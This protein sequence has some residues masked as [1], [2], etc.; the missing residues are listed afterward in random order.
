ML[1]CETETHSAGRLPYSCIFLSLVPTLKASETRY[2]TRVWPAGRNVLVLS[3]SSDSCDGPDACT[4]TR[5]PGAWRFLRHIGATGFRVK[6]A[7]CQEAVWLGRSCF[8]GRMVV[9]LRLSR[10]H[11]GVAAMGKTVTT[12][13]VPRNWGEKGLKMKNVNVQCKLHGI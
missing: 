10:V 5:S 9:N 8:G 13:W 2:Y 6:G 11:T 7:V 1:S 3:H 12:N 4:L